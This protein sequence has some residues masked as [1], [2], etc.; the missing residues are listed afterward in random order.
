MVY[1]IL[2][3]GEIMFALKTLTESNNGKIVTEV[4]DNK[5]S[6]KKWTQNLYETC[7]NKDAFTALSIVK[8]RK[9]VPGYSDR[10]VPVA[11]VDVLTK[12]L[13]MG[14]KFTWEVDMYQAPNGVPAG[15]EAN[16]KFAGK[17]RV[18]IKPEVSLGNL[19][20]GNVSLALYVYNSSDRSMRFSIFAGWLV[21]L[22]LNGCF[23]GKSLFTED[24]EKTFV[25]QRHIGTSQQDISIKVEKIAK[26]VMD[27]IENHEYKSFSNYI[28]E[29]MTKEISQA[30]EMTLAY[31]AM[32]ERVKVLP[33]F[34]KK[35]SISRWKN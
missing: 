19:L 20:D 27:Y 22:C 21:W 9:I 23:S 31:S 11:T 8:N 2:T 13:E 35:I 16:Y 34:T 5:K 29:M 18:I 3:K 7:S 17:H 12:L 30:D 1:R 24:G 15:E 26:A 32:L 4:L 10:Y 25:R 28:S 33:W 6:E 14:L